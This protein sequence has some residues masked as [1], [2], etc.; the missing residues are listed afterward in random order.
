[1]TMT[2]APPAV[3]PAETLELADLWRL[4]VD[5]YHELIR[6][7][8][9]DEDAP[10]ELL[11][12]LLVQKMPKNPPHRVTTP[13][14]RDRLA[15][16]LPAGWF[17]D[18]Q[19]PI[20]TE[21]SEPEPDVS[22]VRGQRRD[23]RRRHPQ[24]SD[25]GMLIEVADASLRRDRTLKKSLYARVSIAVYWIVNLKERIGRGLTNPSGPGRN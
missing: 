2:L 5:Q 12:G 15:E 14:I 11:Y 23:Y 7:G 3:A 8:I 4:S 18:S 25:V 21:D 10:V 1:M 24:P 13:E 16:K 9:I 6:T 17:A 20:T 19:E 22:V